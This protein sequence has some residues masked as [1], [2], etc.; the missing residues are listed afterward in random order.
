MFDGG[1]RRN[2]AI[3][4]SSRCT[5]RNV[6]SMLYGV[7]SLVTAQ[8]ACDCPALLHRFFQVA[9]S[10]Q[11]GSHLADNLIAII[12]LILLTFR[13]DQHGRDAV[14]GARAGAQSYSEYYRSENGPCFMHA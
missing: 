3:L 14:P 5:C 12:E 11:R 7:V 1:V 13:A 9:L 10:R 2:V 8:N 6:I 4:L